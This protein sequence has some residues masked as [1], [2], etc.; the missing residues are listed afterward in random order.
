MPPTLHS[1]RIAKPEGMSLTW[2]PRLVKTPTPIMSATTMAVATT[3]ETVDLPGSREGHAAPVVSVATISVRFST[4]CKACFHRA[5][6]F[7]PIQERLTNTE[8]PRVLVS[9]YLLLTLCP[10]KTTQ[11]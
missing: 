9:K 3:T 1:N 4:A 10:T 8:A 5:G 11:L 2:K 7:Q 6:R